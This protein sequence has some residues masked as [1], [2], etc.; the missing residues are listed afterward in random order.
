M[1]GLVNPKLA[2]LNLEPISATHKGFGK[3][4]NYPFAN[5]T[6]RCDCNSSKGSFEVQ[7]NKLFT[8]LERNK[9]KSRIIE[10]NGTSGLNFIVTNGLSSDEVVVIEG[11]KQCQ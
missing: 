6:K 4:R 7:E 1:N 10:T 5:S 11:V 3:Q 9:V 8:L 2:R